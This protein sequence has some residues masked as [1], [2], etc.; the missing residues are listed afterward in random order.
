MTWVKH[1]IDIL[2][3]VVLGFVLRF[4]IS[5]T[6]SYSNDELSAI[7]RLRYTNFSDLIELGVKQGDMHPAGIQ[8]FMKAWA[9]VA[10]TSEIAMRFPFVLGGTFSIFLLFLI[11]KDWFNRNVGLL[12]AGFLTFLYFPI[13]NAEFARPYSLGLLIS[14][15]V[16]YLYGKVL[17]ESERRYKNAIFLGL[18]FAAGM[19]THYFLFL[20]VGF[21]G[22]TGLIFLN[23]QNWKAYILAGMIGICL[24]LPHVE[25][26]KYHLSVGGLQWLERPTWDWL[27]QFLF[28][29][30]NSSWLVTI[31]VLIMVI[32]ALFFARNHFKRRYLLLVAGWFFGIFIIGFIFSYWSTPV[33]KFPV[34]LFALPYFLLLIST[35]LVR[36]TKYNYL[37]VGLMAVLAFSTIFEKDLFGNSHFELFKEPGLK[38]NEWTKKYGEENVYTV[39]NL[40]NPNYM[41]FYAPA[42]GGDSIDFDWSTL[43]FDSDIQLRRDLKQRSEEYCILG[44]SSRL[45][46]VQVFETVKEFYPTIIDYEQY[47]NAAVFLFGKNGRT[48]PQP[49]YKLAAS[50]NENGI[51]KWNYEPKLLVKNTNS[52][53]GYQLDSVNIYGPSFTFTKPD[54]PKLEHGYVKVVVEALMDSL[55]QL[56]VAFTAKRN[57]AEVMS[58]DASLWMG[59]DLEEMIQTSPN[60]TGYFAF[61]IPK[62]IKDTDQL[63]INLWNR[64]GT[65]ILIKR[66]EIY[67]TENWWN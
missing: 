10:G 19:Y 16:A 44:F 22:V 63:T 11:G 54:L 23:A 55:G 2:V 43:E 45:T 48:L 50:F 1:N 59:H 3:L 53:N 28:H 64:S 15:S 29:A 38:I 31:S 47:N 49:T 25:I 34:M 14:L 6:H 60:K 33:L 37:L 8:V 21:I 65:P 61:E 41:N 27:F 24:F 46:L 42:W 5:F 20:F 4:T 40:N 12:A 51:G 62:F 32:L 18:A 58:Q 56:T 30:F 36:L 17:F 35:L 9:S 7:S 67:H 39:Y 13:L 26:T 66:F 57:G 52:T